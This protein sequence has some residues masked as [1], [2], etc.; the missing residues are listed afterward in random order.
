MKF[1]I[2]PGGRAGTVCSHPADR[3]AI[4]ELIRDLAGSAPFVVR[5]YVHFLGADPAPG[6]AESIGARDGLLRLTMPDDWYVTD[7][8]E[9]DL[10]V[11][12]IPEVADIAGWLAFLDRVV[13]RYGHLV[14]YLQVTLEANFPI[15]LIDGSA[16]GVLDALTKGIPY[17][18]AALDRRG[19]EGV[20][21]GFSVAEPAEWLGGDDAFWNHLSAQDPPTSVDYVGLGLYPDA[22]SAVAPRG[23]PGDTASLT[24]AA[25]DHLR[26]RSLPRAHIP[27]EIPIHV[28]ENGSP[29]GA[30]R[31]PTS[32]CDSL[33]D[34]WRAILSVRDALN[35]AQYELFGLRDADSASD[36]PVGTL[37]LVTD[38][39]PSFALY[40]ALVRD[41]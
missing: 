34:M 12:Y 17:A 3:V 9:L 31:S 19:L 33:T 16:P 35:V 40:R 4:D 25:L 29:S 32:Q 41:H 38:A 14:R 27:P 1:G 23:T 39:K 6:R 5:E 13:D 8:R 36:Q 28:V 18:R 15:P 20:Q 22:F 30:P 11:S 10:V 26:N 37:G 7:S 21:V 2:Y 24:V